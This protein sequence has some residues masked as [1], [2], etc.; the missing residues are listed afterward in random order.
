MEHKMR[1]SRIYSSPQFILSMFVLSLAM[2]FGGGQGT[3][4]DTLTQLTAIVLLVLLYRKHSNLSKW[5]KS[6]L[7]ALIPLVPVLLF[8]L[9]LPNFLTDLGIARN[10]LRNSLNP[11][12]G[13]LGGQS[14]LSTSA[15]ERALFW[16]LPAIAIY[17][18]ALQFNRQQKRLAIVVL[19]TWI[20]VGAVLGLAQKAGGLDSALY[21]Y[22]NTN[23]GSAVGLFA[24]SNHYAISMAASLPLIWAG[25]TVLFNQRSKKSVNPLWFVMY[26]G[27]AVLFILGFMLSGSR[28]G[29][30]LGMLGCLLMLPAIILADEHKGAK[31]WLFAFLAV[32]L[33]F[34]VQI[35]LYFISLKFETDPLDDLRWQ[36]FPITAQAA[37]QFGPWGSGPG[38]FWFVF[39]QY[40]NFLTGN[41]IAN[42]AHNDYIE[43]WLEMRWLFLIAALVACTAFLWQGVKIWFRSTGLE[44]ESVLLARSAWIGI[45]LL[46][47]H[48]AV[49]YPLRTTALSTMIALFAAFL[50]S[51]EAKAILDD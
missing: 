22:T 28:A 35:G 21:F 18:S 12:I 27:L 32:G 30:A 48:S 36:L 45:L 13:D 39:P 14:G 37:S 1:S 20:F 38:S 24:N 29:L 44:D 46:L 43:L 31:H 19:L 33:F 11:V 25:L 49:D 41:V 4:G 34:T 23:Y 2:V 8:L 5:P 42:H 7:Y 26:S 16:L 6:S 10:D 40:D 47:L 15:V 3:L 9:P 51:V 17:L 50:A